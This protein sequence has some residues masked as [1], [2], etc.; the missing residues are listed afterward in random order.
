VERLLEISKSLLCK[1]EG[2][3]HVSFAIRKSRIVAVATNV[4]KTH[5]KTKGYK[6]TRGGNY[7]PVLHSEANLILKLRN[8]HKKCDLYNVRVMRDGSIGMSKP[9]LNCMRYLD[10]FQKVFYTDWNGE[11]DKL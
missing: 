11:F 10:R 4:Y 1:R 6:P 3:F 5:P 8:Y 9:C 2:N 7:I